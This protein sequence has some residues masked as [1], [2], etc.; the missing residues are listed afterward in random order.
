MNKVFILVGEASGDL[1]AS[2]LVKEMNS[3]KPSLEWEGWGGDLLQKQGVNLKNHIKNLS[4]MGF[5][6][7]ILN[8][9]T[10]LNNFNLCKEQIES[11]QPDMLILVDYP[12]FNL[13]MA[14]WA[15]SKG[16]SVTYYISP[17][18]W[19]WR[20]S[21]IKVIKETVDKMYCILPFEKAYYEK[22]AFSVSYF[23]HPLIDEIQNYL[24]ENKTIPVKTKDVIAILPGSREQEVKRTLAVMLEAAVKY[25]EFKT[26]VA[27]SSNL[28]SSFYSQYKKDYPFAE[29]VSGKTYELL[30]IADFAIVTSGTATL[31]TAIFKVPQ[32]VCYR[33]SF[34]SYKIAKF[35]VNIR[36]ISLVNLIMDREV[37]VEL[38][39]GKVS[40]KA[41][42][43]ELDLLMY[44]DSCRQSLLKDYEELIVL[45]GNEGCSK[46]I[47]RDLLGFYSA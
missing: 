39:Q 43:R 28:P 9:R 5:L 22:E 14:K 25:T 11:F 33:S 29:F 18:I 35:L 46:K 12:G 1:H 2:N 40:K 44:N 37:V 41:I 7:V 34:L 20:A 36:F 26:V 17:Q 16:I 27:C 13:R 8:I 38:I 19:A 45:L 30:S 24:N 3:A 6:E 47:A 31:E 10:I 42:Q 15:K 23:G 21:R 4:F 32:V